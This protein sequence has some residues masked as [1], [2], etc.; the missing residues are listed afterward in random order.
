MGIKTAELTDS[1]D[2]PATDESILVA[3]VAFANGAPLTLHLGKKTV[4]ATNAQRRDFVRLL[5][6]V[7]SGRIEMQDI[8]PVLGITRGIKLSYVIIG[9]SD[10]VPRLA[11]HRAFR[12]VRAV[13]AL[14]A[15]LALDTT[16]KSGSKV[17]RCKWQHCKTPFF[18]PQQNRKGGPPKRTYCSAEHLKEHHN[19][20]ERRFPKE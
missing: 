4:M 13:L 12:T 19:S 11:V 17:C 8:A 1:P 9:G 15:V 6:S 7:T 18:I 16:H 14:A 20:V 10:G 2:R 5:E 3:A